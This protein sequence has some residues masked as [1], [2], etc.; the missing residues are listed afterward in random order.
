[1]PQASD[2]RG[3]SVETRKLPREFRRQCP[4]TDFAR[5]MRTR[6]WT[7]IAIWT[8]LIVLF[9]G[10]TQWLGGMLLLTQDRFVPLVSIFFPVD[11]SRLLVT[12][13]WALAF[14]AVSLL[15]P[16]VVAMTTG[17]G[18]LDPRYRAMVAANGHCG[19][20]GYK[21]M[22]L[23]PERDGCTVCPECGSAWRCNEVEKTQTDAKPEHE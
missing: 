8:P 18:I 11:I 3:K 16:V 15:L 19:A 9:I 4:P 6:Y 14:L 23:Q 17:W 1:M 22:D 5:R 12:I 13:F 21:I 20:C 7:A 10:A 2:H